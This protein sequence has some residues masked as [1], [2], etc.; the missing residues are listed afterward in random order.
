MW[1]GTD[2]ALLGRSKGR[3]LRSQASLV[4]GAVGPEL[5]PFLP[6]RA[7]SSLVGD[8]VLYDERLNALRVGDGEPEPDGSTIIPHVKHIVIKAERLGKVLHHLR[9]MI[10]RVSEL[11]DAGRIAVTESRIIGGNEVI[12]PGEPRQ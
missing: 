9:Y 3:E 4:R 7:E 8:G 1:I 11:L 6:E 10:E 12:A 2:M 5:S